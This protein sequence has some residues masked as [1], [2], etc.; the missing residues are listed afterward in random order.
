MS[1]RLTAERTAALWNGGRRCII[2]TVQRTAPMDLCF[3]QELPMTALRLLA[4]T[5]LATSALTMAMPVAAVAQSVDQNRNCQTI[6]NCQYTKGGSFRGCVSSYSC[7]ACRFV[8]AKCTVGTA[9][10]VCRRQV[11]DWGG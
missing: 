5:A 2:I 6:R 9:V 10:G 1:T 4:V 7:R 11:C 3:P 8:P